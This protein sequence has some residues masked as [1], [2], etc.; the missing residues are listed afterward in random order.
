MF[1]RAGRTQRAQ[2]ADVIARAV[3]VL[4]LAALAVI[5]VVDLPATLG[6][7]PLAGIGYVG[8]IAAA[9]LIG[10]VMI[11]RSYWLT[12]AA[13]GGLAV[14]AMG[15]EVAARRPGCATDRPIPAEARRRPPGGQPL[16]S[17]AGITRA[18][19]ITHRPVNSTALLSVLVVSARSERTSPRR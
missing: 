4:A 10:G 18:P 5:D 8:I 12:W 16:S 11:T 17:P 9:V 1:D 14:S 2:G 13:A 19:R 6:Q 3:G 7:T 15:Q